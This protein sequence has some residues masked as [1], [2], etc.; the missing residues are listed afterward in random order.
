MTEPLTAK[1]SVRMVV[2]LNSAETPPMVS[3]VVMLPP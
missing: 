2:E 1:G 3:V